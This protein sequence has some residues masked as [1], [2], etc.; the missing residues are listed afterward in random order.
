M[1]KIE[2]DVCGWNSVFCWQLIELIV[3][4][5]ESIIAGMFWYYTC[6]DKKHTCS[7]FACKLDLLTG[8]ICL[9]N[10]G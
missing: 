4:A 9:S 10:C 3:F 1:I 2:T 6:F 5:S 7:L 8:Y